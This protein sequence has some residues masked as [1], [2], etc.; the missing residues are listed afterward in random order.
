MTPQYFYITL[1]L[2][3]KEK[4]SEDQFNMLV[5]LNKHR[6]RGVVSYLSYTQ[7]LN[8][9]DLNL[10]TDP[11]CKV[12]AIERAKYFLSNVEVDDYTLTAQEY[13]DLRIYMRQHFIYD[14]EDHSY[15]QY[16]SEGHAYV[17]KRTN[18]CFYL[19]IREDLRD[20][21]A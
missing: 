9:Y 6:I 8:H 19:I 5:S 17:L 7:T 1:M 15:I 3:S 4:L 2:H 11:D 21:E 18:N 10:Y 20:E 12:D 14:H 16:F 13:K